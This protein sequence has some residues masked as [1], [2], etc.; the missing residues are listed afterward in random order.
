MSRRKVRLNVTQS[1][2][3]ILHVRDY[4]V[5]NSRNHGTDVAIPDAYRVHHMYLVLSLSTNIDTEQNSGCCEA[6]GLHNWAATG[7]QRVWENKKVI[8]AVVIECARVLSVL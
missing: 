1:S 6:Y 2:F 3:L 4:R 8:L 5:L 7:L